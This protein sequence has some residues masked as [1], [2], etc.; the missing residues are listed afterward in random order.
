M[1][2]VWQV[3]EHCNLACPFCRF[4]RTQ[5][6]KRRNADPQA[7]RRF[8]E[9]LTQYQE[10]TGESVL[11]SWLG[12]EPL[13]WSPLEELSATFVREYGLRVS[14]T[15]NGTTLGSPEVRR[16]LLD[17]YAELTVS[18]DAR[19]DD[20]DRLRGSPGLYATLARNIRL[21]ADEAVALA[22]P[23][24]LRVNIVL[25][26][27]TVGTFAELCE[28]IAGWGIQEIS[29]NQLGGND[30]PEFYPDH[31]L[32]PE[33][34][35]ALQAALPALRDRLAKKGVQLLG[36]SGYLH[37]MNASS[38]DERVPVYDCQPGR[39]FLFIDIEGRVAP[40][41]FTTANC[42]RN[43]VDFTSGADLRR[44]SPMFHDRI[45]QARPAACDDCQSTRVFEKFV[46]HS[47]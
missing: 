3:T 4:D 5:G 38:R 6:G 11:V 9:C 2:V 24:K 27:Q 39:K 19:G 22:K 17:H 47:S 1:I 37:R 28:E 12:G 41:S 18:V 25:M 31:R 35:L 44:L 29:F 33:Q 36:S 10:E 40:C 26:K 20:H 21:L 7:I 8:G 46:V 14:T 15:T 42:G 16:H 45:V 30:R 13:R 43:I 23:I 32:L 34:V